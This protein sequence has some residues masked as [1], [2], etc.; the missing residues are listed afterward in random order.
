LFNLLPKG[1]KQRT[2]KM[3]LQDI[4]EIVYP[5][6][7]ISTSAATL[8]ILCKVNKRFYKE[9]NTECNIQS[10]D[11]W[12]HNNAEEF[13]FKNT[14][15]YYRESLRVNQSIQFSLL[16]GRNDDAE[17]HEG[18]VS[19]NDDKTVSMC[20]TSG[21]HNDDDIYVSDT[22]FVSRTFP[23]IKSLEMIK[24][25]FRNNRFHSWQ[26]LKNRTYY[27]SAIMEMYDLESD[28]YMSYGVN[29]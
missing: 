12:F 24:N 17:V 2:L 16:T 26:M 10:V 15:N 8:S 3:N 11:E 14:A 1:Q 18:I 23:N 21:E 4:A 19:F 5:L 27:I 7:K 29:E 22:P 13:L 20:I 6:L 28:R 9:F 25:I